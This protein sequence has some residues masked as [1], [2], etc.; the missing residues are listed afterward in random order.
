MGTFEQQAVAQQRLE[1]VEPAARFAEY[2]LR[3]EKGG[4]DEITTSPTTPNIK[5]PLDPPQTP[6]SPSNPS[7][8]AHVSV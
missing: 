6:P 7:W 5:V 4:A 8:R 3:K 2:Q 1:E